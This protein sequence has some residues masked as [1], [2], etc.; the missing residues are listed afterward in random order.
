MKPRFAIYPLFLILTVLPLFLKAQPAHNP[1]Y[2]D[3][4]EAYK[5]IAVKKMHE[6]GIPA[7]ITLSQG[8]LESGSGKSALAVEA[9]NH[10]GIKCHKEWTGMT[11]T[12]DDDTKNEC[13]RKYA[14]AEE[15]FNDHSLFLTTRPRYASLFTLDLKDYKGWA[16]GLKSAG[17]ATNPKYAEILIRIIEENELY[18]YDSPSASN[19]IAQ[20]HHKKEKVTKKA[21]KPGKN[22]PLG[23]RLSPGELKFEE[24]YT[25]NRSVY[26][27]NGVKVTFARSGDNARTLAEDFGIHSF[28]ILKYNELGKNEAITEGQA[29]YIVPK[30][31]KSKERNE[32]RVSDGETMR[33]ISQ[34]YGIKLKS[35]YKINKI[36]PGHEPKE[37]MVIKLKR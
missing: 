24:I 5:E 6:Y 3:Y 2:L 12:M 9:N 25:G 22:Q 30:K 1:A 28:Q 17:Y 14:S 31:N 15:S 18:L 11:Y 13:F 21:T 36:K 8:I 23:I 19:A 29:I 4:I 33:E 35:I 34:Y 32:H 37:G 26:L 16:Y 20:K 27:N 10:F 7:S